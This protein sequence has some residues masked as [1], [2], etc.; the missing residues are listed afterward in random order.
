MPWVVEAIHVPLPREKKSQEADA[1]ILAGLVY[2]KKHEVVPQ[3]ALGH[4]TIGRLPVVCI[5]PKSMFGIVVI[6]RDTIVPQECEELFAI[7]L[8]PLPIFVNKLRR[9]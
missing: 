9:E 6:P 7:L 8:E 5:W 1:S 3:A 2:R 4:L